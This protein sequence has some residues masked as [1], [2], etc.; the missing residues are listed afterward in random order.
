MDTV[1]NLTN[2]ASRV[3]WGEDTTDTTSNQ[4]A[5]REPVAGQMGNVEAGEPYDKGNLG[6]CSI[7]L[8]RR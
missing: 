1:T 6:T 3:I 2:A 8:L 5:G 7:A 4:T